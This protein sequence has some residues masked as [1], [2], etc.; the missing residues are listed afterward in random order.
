MRNLFQNALTKYFSCQLLRTR[1]Q[2][3]L[4]QTEMAECLAMDRRSYVELEYGRHCCSAVT[5]VLYLLY[6]CEDPNA[7]LMD[8]KTIWEQEYA[9]V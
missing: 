9:S 5:L 1:D 8:C 7:F 4:S 3:G 2:L 6:C